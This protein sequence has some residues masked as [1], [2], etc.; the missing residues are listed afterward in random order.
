MKLQH[1]NGDTSNDSKVD[2]GA[3][4]QARW[5][6]KPVQDTDIEFDNNSDVQVGPYETPVALQKK[7]TIVVQSELGSESAGEA[8]V[9]KQLESLNLKKKGKGQRPVPDGA[10]Q[11]SVWDKVI[12]NKWLLTILQI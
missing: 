7:K 12:D 9:E 2:N 11:V 10:T 1:T 5:K 3:T 4:P 8:Q 6:D